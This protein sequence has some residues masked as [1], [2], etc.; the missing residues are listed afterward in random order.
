MQ[1]LLVLCLLFV[2][3]IADGIFVTIRSYNDKSTL[4]QVDNKYEEDTIKVQK[5]TGPVTI[6]V[7][8]LGLGLCIYLMFK[9]KS[10]SSVSSEVKQIDE[11]KPVSNF[12]FQF[13]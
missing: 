13:Y 4:I 8:V 1:E 5:I 9:T 7:G 11:V 12:G 2:I 3:I 10:S 6:G